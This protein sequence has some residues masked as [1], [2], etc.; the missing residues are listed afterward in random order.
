MLEGSLAAS[1]S[2]DVAAENVVVAAVWSYHSAQAPCWTGREW[3]GC[4]NFSKETISELSLMENVSQ[5]DAAAG[6]AT[7]WF[8]MCQARHQKM[9]VGYLQHF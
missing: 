7:W 9:N 5:V 1:A 3:K 4:S 2:A 8:V 6:E